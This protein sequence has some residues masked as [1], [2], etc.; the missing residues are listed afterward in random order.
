MPGRYNLERFVQAQDPVYDSVCTELRRGAKTSHWMWFIFPQLTQLGRSATAQ[1]YGISSLAEATAYWQH[2]VLGARL[3]ECSA[4]VLA[5][6]DKTALQIFGRPDDLKFHSSM[7][8]FKQAA[9]Q[10]PVFGR[11]LEKYYRGERDSR[12]LELLR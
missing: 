5:V 1:Y 8:L 2:P 12:T 3:V 6:E 4:L 7:T 10:E 11:A 9:P